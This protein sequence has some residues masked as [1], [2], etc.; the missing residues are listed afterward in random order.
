[1]PTIDYQL[2]SVRDAFDFGPIVGI[3]R[4]A[5]LAALDKHGPLANQPWTGMY[6]LRLKMSV[7]R[8][9]FRI[10]EYLYTIHHPDVRPTGEKQLDYVDP[11]NEDLQRDCELVCTN[12][13]RTIGAFLEPRFR[14]VPTPTTTFPV[15]AS[16]IIPVRN[17]VKT[18]ADAIGSVLE[19]KTDFP[20][21][22]IIV[23]NHSSDGTSHILAELSAKHANVHAMT[24]ARTDL[25]IGGCW[26]HAVMSKQCGRYAVQLDS[27]DLY[28]GTSVLQQI[29]D[30]LQDGPYALVVG[31]YRLVDMNL[32]ELPPG[33]IDHREWSHDN[34]R[35]NLLRVNGM[36]AP[37]A[38]DTHI[39]RANPMPN[40]SYGEDYC[41]AMRFSREYEVGRIYDPIYLCRRW[42]GNTDAALPIDIANTYDTYKDRLRTLEILARQQMNEKGHVG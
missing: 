20:F 15:T 2:G 35:N 31:S 24:P 18:V 32:D 25:G 27:D 40:V 23:D 10:P 9:P 19:Q 7:D 34:G 22:I 39:F 16:V 14:P 6:E 26:N 42:E 38:F 17:R 12:Y 28:S 21:N 4:R 1:H 36:G 29:V 13:L 5:A 37:R 3:S 41:V 11:R 33:V 30:T 8:L